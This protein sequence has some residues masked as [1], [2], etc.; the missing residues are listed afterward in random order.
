MASI[1]KASS[2]P[3]ALTVCT[4][5]ATTDFVN[6]LNY[7]GCNV[8]QSMGYDHNTGN[9]Y[10]YAH[11][12]TANGNR[13]INVCMT[14]IVD[15]ATGAC[16]EVG[17][18][19]PSGQTCLF[20]PT[21]QESDLFTMGVDPTEFNVSPSSLTMA[22][23]QVR[24]LDINWTPWNAAAAKV[25]WASSDESV[26]TVNPYGYV[27]AVGEGNVEISATAQ[28]WDQW[29]GENGEWVDRTA[30]CQL[31]VVGS[32][33]GIYGYVIMDYSNAD[34]NQSWVTYSDKMPGQVT[35]VAKQYVTTT[36]MDGAPAESL[37]LW[38]GG[39][40]YNGCVHTVNT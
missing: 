3:W 35:Q 27:T 34:N 6:E 23:A 31:Q 22:Q 37:A 13:Y 38:Q 39:T 28:V 24:R 32:N 33:D 7:S 18:Y 40:Y 15:L 5:V 36:G 26:A 29:S 12:Q 20:V 10:W 9:M 30:T 2:T 14:Y 16:T 11:S 1:P 4:Y 8:I 21:D 19:G 17:T 25:T